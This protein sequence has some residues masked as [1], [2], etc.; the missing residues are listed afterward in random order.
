IGHRRCLICR[1]VPES[2]H[3]T[4]SNR[5][6][7]LLSEHIIEATGVRKLYD[8]GRHRVEALA[9][10]DFTVCRGEVVAVMGP[11]GSGKTTLLNCLSGLDTIDSGRVRIAGRDL[12]DLTDNQK[13]D[14]RARQM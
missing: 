10:V 14:F 11:S 2:Q 9:G 4:T 5:G 8:T 13:T 12:R 6:P 3:P 7:G 1:I